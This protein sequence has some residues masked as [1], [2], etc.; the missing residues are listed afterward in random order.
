MDRPQIFWD[1]FRKAFRR[2]LPSWKA[3][4][5]TADW[6]KLITAS[7]TDACN[8]YG[9]NPHRELEVRYEGNGRIDVYAV[10]KRTGAI[11]VAFETELARWGYNG[12]SGKDWREEF[13]K[14]CKIKAELRVLS[15]YFKNGTGGKFHEFL[16]DKLNLMK[17]NFDERCD[18]DFCFI[19]GPERSR[20]DPEQPWLAYSLEPNFTLREL[21]SSKPLIPWRLYERKDSP[22]E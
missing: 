17:G 14:L 11:V 22:E 13:Q 4:D 19:F 16:Q 12:S 15:S 18:G 3:G 21:T 6:T 1:C 10:D 20:K 8:D 9:Q 5:A 7:T 2:K